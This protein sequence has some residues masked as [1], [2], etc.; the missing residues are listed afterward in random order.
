MDY[1]Y[2]N[3]W[4]M[5]HVKFLWLETDNKNELYSLS[6]GGKFW[7]QKQSKVESA[8]ELRRGSDF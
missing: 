8:G 7:G 5:G 1:V 4:P 3:L 6:N 2:I